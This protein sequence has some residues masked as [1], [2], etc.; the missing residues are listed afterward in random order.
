MPQEIWECKCLEVFHRFIW[1][2]SSDC[3]SRFTGKFALLYLVFIETFSFI[4]SSYT[5]HKGMKWG[6]YLSRLRNVN[7][8]CECVTK[9]SKSLEQSNTGKVLFLGC[10]FAFLFVENKTFFCCCRYFAFMVVCHLPLIHWITLGLL[11]VS[12]KSLTRFVNIFFTIL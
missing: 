4:H 11:I 5:L 1:L 3:I 2:P 8:E 10:K 12:R 9:Q 7:N 6:T